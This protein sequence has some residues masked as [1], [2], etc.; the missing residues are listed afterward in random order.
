MEIAVRGTESK[1]PINPNTEPK[2]KIPRI[3][4]NG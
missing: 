2:K 4:K 1:I 3:I